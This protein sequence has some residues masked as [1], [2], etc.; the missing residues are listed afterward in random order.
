MTTEDQWEVEI[1]IRR[2][3]RC[4]GI[5]KALGDTPGAA[6]W[7]ATTDLKDGVRGLRDPD[8]RR[9]GAAGQGGEQRMTMRC[10]LCGRCG[11]RAV[12]AQELAWGPR[13]R[14]LGSSAQMRRTRLPEV[15]SSPEPCG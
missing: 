2:N 9:D 8:W 7:K 10:L 4:I 12:R 14:R 11:E 3:G 13:V 6:L 1:R 5:T 15:S